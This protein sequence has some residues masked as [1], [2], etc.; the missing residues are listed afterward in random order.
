MFPPTAFGRTAVF[1]LAA[2]ASLVTVGL[3]SRADDLNQPPILYDTATP[4]NAVSR[5]KREVATGRV[6]LAFD[7]DRGYLK[8][9]LAAL[10]VPESSL[11]P[12][13]PETFQTMPS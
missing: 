8:S 4:D 10:K 3:R 2:L 13:P 9:V 12:G 6:K 7:E 5:L 11:E 1:S